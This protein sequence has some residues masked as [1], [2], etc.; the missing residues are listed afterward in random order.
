MT[1]DS[2]DLTT[3]GPHVLTIAVGHSGVILAD[4]KRHLVGLGL[5]PAV[6]QSLCCQLNN[7]A[8]LKVLALTKAKSE[9]ETRLI[10]RA[11]AAG[12]SF[13]TNW[14]LNDNYCAECRSCDG[15]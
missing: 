10:K 7:L 12:H 14:G 9:L 4:T 8:A 15:H 1:S 11:T 6:A 2:G 5:T 3:G 13:R